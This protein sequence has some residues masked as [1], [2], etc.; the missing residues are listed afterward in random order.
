MCVC[1]C[2]SVCL[3]VCRWDVKHNQPT[4]YMNPLMTIY[5]NVSPN[6]IFALPDTL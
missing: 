3:S 5:Q 1:V 4:M 2:L 6:I